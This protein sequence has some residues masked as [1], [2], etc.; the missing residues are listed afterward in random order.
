LA[1]FGSWARNEASEE[2]DI[3]IL[4]DFSP[5]ADLLDLSGL[6]IYLEDLFG[7]TVDVVPK[8]A[9]REELKAAILADATYI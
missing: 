8:R 3:D 4:V 9:I 6:K 5:G 1:L 7:R 2:S